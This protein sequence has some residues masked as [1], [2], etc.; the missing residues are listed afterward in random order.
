MKNL[1]TVAIVPY[2]FAVVAFVGPLS[3]NSEQV[4][5]LMVILRDRGFLEQF[6]SFGIRTERRVRKIVGGYE[7]VFDQP[8]DHY[9]VGAVADAMVDRARRELGAA[10]RRATGQ[11]AYFSRI[12][13]PML[14]LVAS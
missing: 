13:G 3:A 7:E 5:D 2:G 11:R 6:P 9:I 12:S 14:G 1:S 4:G 8:K 10:I